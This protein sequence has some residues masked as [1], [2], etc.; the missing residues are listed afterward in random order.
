MWYEPD[1]LTRAKCAALFGMSSEVS[2][3]NGIYGPRERAQ[4]D[5]TAI[6]K[7]L[8]SEDQANFV[9]FLRW[10][11]E[12]SLRSQLDSTGRKF[13]KRL[14]QDYVSGESQESQ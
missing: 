12:S 13:L 1:A 10:F 6:Y 11:E 7:K 8:S 4:A 2:S 5:L 3:R 14:M 9:A